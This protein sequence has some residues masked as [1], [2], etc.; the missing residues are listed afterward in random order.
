MGFL[1]LWIFITGP[2][3]KKI[4]NHICYLFCYCDQLYFISKR[5]K[6]LLSK[7]ILLASKKKII[8]SRPILKSYALLKVVNF[9]SSTTITR[10]A[11]H[12]KK[13]AIY[14]YYTYVPT[15]IISF[16]HPSSPHEFYFL[17]GIKFLLES[18]STLSSLK[19]R[20]VVINYSSFV[21]QYKYSPSPIAPSLIVYA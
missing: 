17:R 12:L 20:L 5:R 6:T 19:V 1:W 8:S 11:I 18:H 15:T 21:P 13:H 3:K 7:L 14:N 4:K 16:Y 2:P 10:Y 9:L